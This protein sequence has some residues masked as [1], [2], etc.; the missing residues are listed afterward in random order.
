RTCGQAPLRGERPAARRIRH[1]LAEP[2]TA[3]AGLALIA[4]MGATVVDVVARHAFNA[5]LPGAVEMVELAMVWATFLGIAAAFFIG[6]HITV[7]LVDAALG[8]VAA[9]R[10]RT[11]A[12]M[13]ATLLC[14]VLAFLAY[15]ELLDAIDWG[16]T[17]VDLGIPHTAYWVAI[18]AGFVMG[19]LLSF[20]QLLTG[21]SD[22]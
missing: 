14:G 4:M 8:P 19:T 6:G 11:F 20:A 17:T 2:L 21:G 5:P 10:V 9:R 3:L 7:D 22:S 1:T 15:R 12:A 13:V 16:D 18:F